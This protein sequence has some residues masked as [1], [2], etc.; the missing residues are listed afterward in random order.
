M[1]IVYIEI[2]IINVTKNKYTNQERIS[3]K[4]EEYF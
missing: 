4:I 1:Y 2:R 3:E